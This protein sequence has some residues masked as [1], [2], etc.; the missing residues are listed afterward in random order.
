MALRA[1]AA[2]KGAP[3]RLGAARRW[4]VCLLMARFSFRALSIRHKL[5]ALGLLPLLLALPLLAVVLI[6]WGDSA[7]DALLITK[8]RSDLAVA[9]G[10]F[11]RVQAEVGASTLAVAQ[12]H[13]VVD[14]LQRDD[15]ATQARLLTRAKQQHALEFLELLPPDASAI[16]ANDAASGEGLARV[17]LL[18]GAQFERIA[19]DLAGRVPVKLVPTRN[20][21]PTERTSEDRA[22]VMLAQAPVRALDGRPLGLLRG[23]V[24][25]NRNLALID[26]INEIVYPQGSLPFGSQGTATLF[27]D[28]VRVS[29]NVRLFSHDN[30]RAIGT[31]VSQAVRDAALGR[32]ETWLGRAF[33][34]NDWYVSAYAPLSNAAGRRIG[35]LYVG[36]LESPFQQ[37]EVGRAVRHERRHAGA[38]GGGDG[39][40]AGVGAPHLRADRTHDAH[41]ADGRGRRHDGACAGGRQHR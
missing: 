37:R 16:A 33:V 26:H 3:N 34:V 7:L 38:D 15:R 32:G 6:V 41:H 29:T 35:M 39:A 5:L 13:T 11:E 36:F 9:H 30:E 28:D 12:S 10:Y 22:M 2:P 4:L 40:R 23:G 18:E 24:L 31:R 20:A 21:A 17:V 8:I 1:G 19:P 27:L 25:L 14:A